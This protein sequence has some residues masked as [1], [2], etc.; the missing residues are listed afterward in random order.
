[1]NVLIT[2][3]YSALINGTAGSL[4]GNRIY[5][6]AAPEGINMPYIVFFIVNSSPDD[7][8]SNTL[9]YT[10]IQFSIFSTSQSMSEIVAIYKAIKT[11]FDDAQITL[12]AGKMVTMHRD[13]LMTDTETV[14]T[15]NGTETVKHWV[16]DYGILV[17]D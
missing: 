1:M 17:H 3:I 8:F 16:V 9:E 15:E 11:V 10:T 7:P 14:T 13:N 5:L 6:D 12:S 4:V 2:A